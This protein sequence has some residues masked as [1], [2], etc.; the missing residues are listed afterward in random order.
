MNLIIN[1]EKPDRN[2]YIE[3]VVS[4]TIVMS[5]TFTV[6]TRFLILNAPFLQ[7]ISFFMFC[8]TS[9]LVFFYQKEHYGIN[10]YNKFLFVFICVYYGFLFYDMFLFPKLNILQIAFIPHSI[11]SFILQFL[12]LISLMLSADTII[13]HFNLKYF[14]WM[15]AV[16]C[17]LLSF[18]YIKTTTLLTIIEDDQNPNVISK[19]TIAYTNAPVLLISVLYIQKFWYED[20]LN[21]IPYFAISAL[22]GYIVL[23]MGERG[24]ILSIVISLVLITYYLNNASLKYTVCICLLILVIYINI[25]TILEFLG[26]FFPTAAEKFHM[27]IKEGDTNA[28]LSTSSGNDGVFVLGIKEFSSNPL[29]G[30]YFRLYRSHTFTGSYPHNLF[31]E[32]LMTMGLFGFL[33]FVYLIFTTLKNA[34][35]RFKMYF[36][37]EGMIVFAFFL[38]TFSRLLVSH[39]IAFYTPFW[40]FFYILS[41]ISVEKEENL[42]DQ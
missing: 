8:L 26:Y 38:L 18:W 23:S 14:L 3:T 1:S 19:M 32:I 40:L 12:I 6:C 35:T 20:I 21:L 11:L 29:F 27:T 2:I 28:R 30:S 31:I 5:T 36:S 25:D 17:V 4:L 22:S 37:Y 34:N 39:T 33:P 7:T 42:L 16:F 10:V 41:T 15:S 13:E 9:I 24:P